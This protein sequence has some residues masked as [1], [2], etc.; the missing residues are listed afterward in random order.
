M[1]GTDCGFRGEEIV[2][3]EVTFDVLLRY[4]ESDVSRTG[5]DVY[6]MPG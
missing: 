6:S 5:S 3:E 1:C 4:G 2:N